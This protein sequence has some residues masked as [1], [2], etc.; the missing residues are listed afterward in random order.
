MMCTMMQAILQE[1]WAKSLQ[2]FLPL[3]PGISIKG[4]MTA[5]HAYCGQRWLL[6]GNPI[7]LA[8]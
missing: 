8:C 1:A 7:S 6:F 5:V 3:G 2:E 4:A